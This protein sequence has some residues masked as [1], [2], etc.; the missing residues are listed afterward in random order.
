MSRQCSL[1]FEHL[2]DFEPAVH[3]FFDDHSNNLQDRVI[4]QNLSK[5][6]FNFRCVRRNATYEK[7]RTKFSLSIQKPSRTGGRRSR[8]DSKRTKVARRQRSQRRNQRARGRRREKRGRE[9]E[10]LNLPF[11]RGRRPSEYLETVLMICSGPA[12]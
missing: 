12:W 9:R 6:R 10:S 3:S 8:G 1:P 5:K 4:Q 11:T 2:D 7:E